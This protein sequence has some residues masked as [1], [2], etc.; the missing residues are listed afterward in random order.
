MNEALL[1]WLMTPEAPDATVTLEE[2]LQRPEWHKWAACRGVGADA[3][4]VDRGAR[5]SRRELCTG[6]TVREQCLEVALRQ[7]LAGHLG[8]DHAGRAQ[9]DA[10][11]A[12]GVR[13]R[14]TTCNS[15]M[16]TCVLTCREVSARTRLTRTPTERT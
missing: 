2:F 16:G 5:Y 13:S 4:V 12:R 3:F 15:D 14:A 1:A 7:V 10:A 11:R 8:R 6:C 9:G